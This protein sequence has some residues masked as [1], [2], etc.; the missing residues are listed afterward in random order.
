MHRDFDD[1]QDEFDQ[2]R[3]QH[4]D[5]LD[6]DQYG[7]DHDPNGEDYYD[8]DVF[9]LEHAKSLFFG[10]GDLAR[11]KGFNCVGEVIPPGDYLDSN[12]KNIQLPKDNP[13]DLYH[14]NN[15]T[16]LD[17]ATMPDTPIDPDEFVTKA[18]G[19]LTA[20]NVLISKDMPDLL[21]RMCRLFNFSIQPNAELPRTVKN[22]VFPAQT[23]IGKS[24][25]VQVYVSMLK[26]HS[27]V[28]VVAKVE[29]AISYCNYINDLSRDEI[30]ARCYYSLTDKNKDD[31]MRVDA[32]LLRNHRCIVI[33][34][35][36]F[37]LVNGFDNVDY[38][39]TYEERP[40]D[41]VAIDEKLS[42]YE[43]FKLDYKD[44]DQLIV[45][46]KKAVDESKQLQGF[47]TSH[48]ALHA[49][50]EFKDFLL[51]KDDKIVTNDNSVTVNRDLGKGA[52]A[53]L[54]AI[55]EVITYSELSN[56]RQSPLKLVDLKNKDAAVKI[57]QSNRIGT[58]ARKRNVIGISSN[59]IVR[60]GDSI[61]KNVSSFYSEKFD[62]PIASCLT[63]IEPGSPMDDTEL[64]SLFDDNC[65]DGEL[66]DEQLKGF[67]DLEKARNDQYG[68][69]FV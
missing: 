8:L 43:Q 5:Q 38:F 29:E 55:G 18:V 42:F 15:R 54:L 37:R 67:Q 59:E 32:S 52:E 68:L 24:V 1:F 6:H 64:H 56:Q 34:H 12:G 48:K 23:G 63:S 26:E 60:M 53:E 51:F 28:V 47:G 10:L 3:Q 66:T 36:M 19:E 30:Y 58:Q 57:L 65:F 14:P 13:H 40:R 16:V 4:H 45:N 11:Y 50:K 33:T 20:K 49:L 61:R 7:D 69:E 41:F 31:P 17:P 21:E 27:S 62:P 25:S 22:L 2:I 46:V 44:L 39:G 9:S 35:N